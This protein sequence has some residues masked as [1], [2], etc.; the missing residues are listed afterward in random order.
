MFGDYLHYLVYREAVDPDSSGRNQVLK[1]DALR[2]LY[3][4]CSYEIHC[5]NLVRKIA[6]FFEQPY[7]VQ[8]DEDV[9]I[10]DNYLHALDEL[11]LALD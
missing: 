11:E 10:V 8:V 4:L 5:V 1:L 3:N 9:C 7:R 2:F 6:H